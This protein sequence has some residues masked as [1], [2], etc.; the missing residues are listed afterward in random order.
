M[1]LSL[2]R[3][4]LAMACS[5]ALSLPAAAQL[6]VSSLPDFQT[7]RATGL[8][9][10]DL[11]SGDR[12]L[13]A[14]D[15]ASAIAVDDPGRRILFSLGAE[16]RQWNYGSPQSSSQVLGTIRKANGDT[17]ALTGLAFGGGRLFGTAMG[18]GW[19]YEISLTTL[20]ATP[21]T[22]PQDFDLV[23][24]LSFDS[25]SGL[26]HA[27]VESISGSEVSCDLYSID[28][29]NGG[30]PTIVGR[31]PDGGSAA[32]VSGGFAY[33]TAGWRRFIGR[34]DLA[35]ASFTPKAYLAP[36]P[37]SPSDVG[38]DFAPS[39]VPSGDARVYCHPSVPS[40]PR[41]PGLRPLGIANAS[42]GSGFVIQHHTL[43]PGARLQ[44]HYSFSGRSSF[45]FLTG[46]RCVRAPVFRLPPVTAA[47]NSS[48]YGLDFN[49]VVAQGVHPGLMA[50]Q[51][52]WYQASI[53]APQTFQSLEFGFTSGL[54]FTIQP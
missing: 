39:L 16:L 33:S 49:A 19:L 24:G 35:I 10:V 4:A 9:H 44:P 8:W 5:S 52:V 3:S 32:C 11:A 22:T 45:P 54:E 17:L 7:G 23:F 40:G 50:G 29:L 36:W 1:R 2:F 21:I 26:F 41:F 28:L 46:S 13:L 38:C 12:S 34:F 43:P 37:Q 14:T 27:A 25:T 15:S 20:V 18:P 53:W 48:V 47:P 31:I 42:S 30:A 6:V 51:T